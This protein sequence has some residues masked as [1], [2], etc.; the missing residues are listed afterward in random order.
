MLVRPSFRDRLSPTG[1]F[2][3]SREAQYRSYLPKS[4][5]IVWSDYHTLLKSVLEFLAFRSVLV[6]RFGCNLVSRICGVCE[7]GHR[8]G[9]AFLVGISETYRRMTSETRQCLVKLCLLHHE[10]NH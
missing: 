10:L 7:N 9:R 3:A 8:E 4:L 5:S 1:P 6:Y 2:V